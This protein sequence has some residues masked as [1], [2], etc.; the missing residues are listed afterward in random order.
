MVHS[1][2]CLGL[3]AVTGERRKMFIYIN[4]YLYMNE[5]LKSQPRSGHESDRIK[6]DITPGRFIT[7]D[8]PFLNIRSQ[9]MLFLSITQL[10]N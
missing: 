6:N 1:Q 3:T 2:F 10:N 5:Q 9:S 8:S 4:T 7:A